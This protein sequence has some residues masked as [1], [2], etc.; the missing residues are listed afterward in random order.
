M[1]FCLI[2]SVPFTCSTETNYH[3]SSILETFR[4]RE[5]NTYRIVKNRTHVWSLLD[6]NEV[7]SSYR[8]CWRN[9]L[10]YWCLRNMQ[11]V[12]HHTVSFC[13][14][15]YYYYFVTCKYVFSMRNVW[16]TCPLQ[17]KSSLSNMWNI[18]DD[19]WWTVTTMV[20]FSFSAYFFS[21]NINL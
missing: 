17:I 21:D 9:S 13:D 18:C 5:N 11:S 14:Y 19:G 3:A 15:Y 1:I 16:R 4:G 8:C 7:L 20:F 12:Q 2:S 10:L 6:C